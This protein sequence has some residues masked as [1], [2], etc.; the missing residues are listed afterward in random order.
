VLHSR[1]NKGSYLTPSAQSKT[2]NGMNYF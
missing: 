2:L 1:E